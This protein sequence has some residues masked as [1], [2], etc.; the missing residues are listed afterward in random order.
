MERA[1][2]SAR[3]GTV[4]LV[5]A[6]PGD[7][8]LL[9]LRA[10]ELLSRADAVVYDRLIHPDVLR[11]ARRGARLMFVGKEGGGEQVPQ[12]EILELLV[13]Q[14]RLGRQVVRLKGGDPFVF[15]RGGEEALG[16][17][18]AGIPFEV[19]PGV[20]SGFAAP[21]AAAI[22]VTHRGLSAN[23]TFATAQLANGEPDWPHLARAA[24]LVL[25]MGA[26]RLEHS[27]RALIAAGRD[28]STP[29]A[30]VEAGTW[31]HQRVVESALGE[32]ATRAKECEIGSPALLVVGEVVSLRAAL[33]A[34]QRRSEAPALARIRR[35]I[36]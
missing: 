9:T 2:V 20:S 10:A 28:P 36:R 31:E 24:T 15:G 3:V 13:A 32:I 5:G 19:V 22:P 33:A 27:T 8:G 21:A 16:L 17:A 1:G 25:F 7:P 30:V 18:A 12:P 14:A 29:A 35:S 11:R 26:H 4:Y 34:F 6:G 23:V